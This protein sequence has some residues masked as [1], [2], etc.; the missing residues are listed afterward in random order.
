M[1]GERDQSILDK[2]KDTDEPVIVFRAQDYLS[3]GVLYNY[4]EMYLHH[5]LDV[6][7]Q[8]NMGFLS[9]LNERINEFNAWQAKNRDRVKY[10]DL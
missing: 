1:I 10:P 7:T 9:A 3:L 2:T 5:F 8:E 4:R 6:E